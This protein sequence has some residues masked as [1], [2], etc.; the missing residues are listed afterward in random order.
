MLLSAC[1]MGKDEEATLPRCLASIRDHVDEIVYV[2]T[3]SHDKSKK[4]AA[5]FGAR[6][7]DFPWTDSFS[8]ARNETLRHARGDWI[9]YIDCDEALHPL[10]G[11][12]P[13]RELLRAATTRAFFVQLRDVDQQTRTQTFATYPQIRLFRNEV[14]FVGRI[15]NQLRFKDGAVIPPPPMS[16]WELIHT[17]YDPVIYETKRKTERA[18]RLLQAELEDRPGDPLLLFYLGR[19]YHRLRRWKAATEALSQAT[20]GLLQN[21]MLLRQTLASFRLLIDAQAAQPMEVPFDALQE[22][23]K[24]ALDVWSTSPDIHYAVARAM[25]DRGAWTGSLHHYGEAERL[26]QDLKPGMPADIPHQIWELYVNWCFALWMSAPESPFV[27][28]RGRELLYKA[29]ETA[30]PD[31]CKTIEEQ[32]RLGAEFFELEPS[33]STPNP[34]HSDLQ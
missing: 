12:P 6:V 2:D 34:P 14:E 11:A 33:C 23:C 29:L 25:T 26:C 31:A 32:L 1:I 17:G 8:E 20:T 3:G 7:F 4:I 16:G 15:H 27:R 19:E 24:R 10:P 28:I 22:T 30:P 13:L 21:A 18:L 5:S 9:L